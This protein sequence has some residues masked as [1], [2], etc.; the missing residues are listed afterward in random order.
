MAPANSLS[1]PNV[2]PRYSPTS[3]SVNRCMDTIRSTCH[4]GALQDAAG[5]RFEHEPR[6]DRPIPSG[7][8]DDGQLSEAQDGHP[9]GAHLQEPAQHLKIQEQAE[10]LYPSAIGQTQCEGV[11]PARQS[12]AHSQRYRAYRDGAV[13]SQRPPNL[14][15]QHHAEGAVTL[16]QVL[17]RA[18]QDAGLS[19]DLRSQLPQSRMGHGERGAALSHPQPESPHQLQHGRH[20]RDETPEHAQPGGFQDS[21]WQGDEPISRRYLA[22]DIL[23]HEDDDMD[24]DA[25]PGTP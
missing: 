9:D 11:L 5:K 25:I 6:R 20:Q 18:D 17:H 10:D 7:L 4:A 12:L 23:H 2:H 22:A 24:E 16:E 3:P 15:S 8:L 13:A 19:T 21:E 1:P 14:F